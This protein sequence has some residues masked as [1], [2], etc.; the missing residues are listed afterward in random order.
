MDR[1]SIL[2]VQV[3]PRCRVWQAQHVFRKKRICNS[4]R[5]KDF[6][7]GEVTDELERRLRHRLDPW[8][9]I[10]GS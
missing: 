6:H 7:G 10:S 5:V 8:V 3:E 9:K 2:E 4:T 1:I